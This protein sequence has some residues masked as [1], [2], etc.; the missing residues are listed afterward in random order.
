M[1]AVHI[2]HHRVEHPAD[3]QDHK[4]IHQREG[5]SR[6]KVELTDSHLDQIDG[7]E[8]GRVAGSAAGDSERFVNARAEWSWGL[9]ERFEQGDIDIDPADDDLASQLGAI[10]LE[11]TSRGQIKIESKDDMA[12]RGMPSPDRADAL[13]LAYATPSKK[14][15]TLGRW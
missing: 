7:Q 15:V 6:A 10:R 2:G 9:R 13:M 3:Q 12:K 4:E 11:Y 8:R 5:R 1:R 14:T